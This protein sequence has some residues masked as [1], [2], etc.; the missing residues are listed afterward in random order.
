MFATIHYENFIEFIDD[1][2]PICETVYC[3]FKQD[4]NEI[5]FKVKKCKIGIVKI[6]EKRCKEIFGARLRLI[7]NTMQNMLVFTTLSEISDDEKY[8]YATLK[9][10]FVS[11]I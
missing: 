9:C 1:L 6:G 11:P 2:E 7:V 3:A 5:R 10:R 4:I 8:L